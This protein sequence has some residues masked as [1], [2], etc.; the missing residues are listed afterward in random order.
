LQAGAPS[1]V[2]LPGAIAE[3]SRLLACSFGPG[4]LSGAFATSANIGS[5]R[6]S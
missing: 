5:S 6:V 2:V 1:S 4:F 3:Q